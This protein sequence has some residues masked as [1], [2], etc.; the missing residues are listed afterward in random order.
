MADAGK[1]WYG[2]AQPGTS[3]GDLFTVST[4]S[5]HITCINVANTTATDATITVSIGNDAVGTRILDRVTVPGRDTLVVNGY[6][7]LANGE[8]MQGL[9]GTASALTL[10]ISGVNET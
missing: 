7:F 4:G 3:A 6:W 8:K 9:Q 1:R 10:T 2:P 5:G